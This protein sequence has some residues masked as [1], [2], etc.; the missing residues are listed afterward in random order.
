M[1]KPV[2]LN[3]L[4]TNEFI[5]VKPDDTP[6]TIGRSRECDLITSSRIKYISRV[7]AEILYKSN[8]DIILFQVSENCNTFCGPEVE[9]EQVYGSK[10]VYTGYRIRFGGDYPLKILSSKDEGVRS[11][12][13]D[14]LED[15]QL[16]I[17]EN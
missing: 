14:R 8:G 6:R 12:I 4:V 5:E 3:D 16:L 7:Q 2:Y 11:R 15:T 13:A 9:E 1:V 17:G 10:I